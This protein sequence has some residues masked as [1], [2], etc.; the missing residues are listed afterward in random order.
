[1]KRQ[2]DA[3]ASNSC[4]SEGLP[5]CEDIVKQ[6]RR[7]TKCYTWSAVLLKNHYVS[8]NATE[9]I[10]ND[11][12]KLCV[13]ENSTF[14]MS[15]TFGLADCLWLCD[16][17]FQYEVLLNDSGEHPHFLSLYMLHF[18]KGCA[19]YRYSIYR[20]LELLTPF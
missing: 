6:M 16:I 5:E 4:K 19:A 3:R 20:L 18:D 15:T 8:F 7:E 10:L 1:M 2:T 11:I 17:S 13:H 12:V 14:V 9:R